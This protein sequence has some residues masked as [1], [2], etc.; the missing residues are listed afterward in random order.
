MGTATGIVPAGQWTHVAFV[1]DNGTGYIYLNGVQVGTA[2]LSSVNTPSGNDSLII[3]QRVAGG[4]ILFSGE[5]D[6]VRI[7][8]V[9]RTQQEIMANMNTFY[10]GP[11]PGLAAYYDMDNGIAGGNNSAS[12]KVFNPINS[13]DGFL[14]NFALTGATSNFVSP[15]ATLSSPVIDTTV[16]QVGLSLI[17]N[18]STAEQYQWIDCSSNLPLPSDT[19]RTFTPPNNGNYAV[20]LTK[21]GCA[22]TSAC[23]NVIGVG[24]E[25]LEVDRTFFISQNPFKESFNLINES[26]K[27]INVH[28]RSIRGRLVQSTFNVNEYK[29]EFNMTNKAPG[30][31]IV[32]IE[33]PTGLT[34]NFKVIKE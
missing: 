12:V 28:V 27:N 4:S 21:N 33:S 19:N 15:G 10:C 20:I 6:E 2:N 8:S 32:T 5:I 1:L 3:G 13:G 25:N 18:D 11:S 22:D 29:T 14:T 24:L 17:A 16:S 23:A 34:K 26:G 31:Y 30:V 7:W 9:A